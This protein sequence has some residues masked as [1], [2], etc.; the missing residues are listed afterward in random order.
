MDRE[1]FLRCVVPDGGGGDHGQVKDRVTGVGRAWERGGEQRQL[2]GR[3]RAE[4]IES[5]SFVAWCQMVAA[6]IMGKSKIASPASAGRGSGA[7]SSASLSGGVEPNGSRA[8]PSLRGAR[9][10]RR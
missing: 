10:W 7:A 5:S 2:V 8:V 3:G 1:Q 6:V 4:W 9:W